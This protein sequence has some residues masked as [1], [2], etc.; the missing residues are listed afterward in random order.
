M[1]KSHV[2]I[3]IDA[4]KHLKTQHS[5][6]IKMFKELLMDKNFL[7][8]IEGIYRNPKTNIIFN[9]KIMN[10]LFFSLKVLC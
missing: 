5:F 6:M 9:V 3:S 8:L 1:N 2:I 7:K 4:Q 10:A